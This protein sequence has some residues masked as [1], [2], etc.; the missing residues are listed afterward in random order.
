M[1]IRYGTVDQARRAARRA[2]GQ[3]WQAK[4]A[5]DVVTLPGASGARSLAS[6]RGVA[7]KTGRSLV[8]NARGV[9]EAVTPAEQARRAGL[10]A[11]VKATQSVKAR[12]APG[13][14]FDVFE[15]V[16]SNSRS[17]GVAVAAAIDE[18]G[19][20]AISALQSK[21]FVVFLEARDLDGGPVDVSPRWPF[22]YS[23]ATW[24]GRGWDWLIDR[25]LNLLQGA[26]I[27]PKQRARFDSVTKTKIKDYKARSIL[28]KH[29]QE[30]VR[31]PKR[32]PGF[33]EEPPAGVPASGE[34]TVPMMVTITI[35]RKL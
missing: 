32:D 28:P 19:R 33:D 29:G 23:P 18:G 6:L 2:W 14:Q 4:V 16:V 22:G 26:K 17:W 7:T 25:M 27:K 9:W 5:G 8:Q 35:E 10:S 15:G 11:A 3:G 12:F 20:L 24:A 13:K 21:R 30:I 34:A 1:R 31:K